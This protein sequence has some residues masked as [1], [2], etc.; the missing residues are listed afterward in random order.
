MDMK[1]LFQ[2]LIILITCTSLFSSCASEDEQKE[3]HY[4]KALEYIKQDNS[5]A[6]IIELRNAVQIDATY[7]DARY[8]LG[9]LYLEEG[10]LKKCFCRAGANSRSRP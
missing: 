7:A 4:R 6:A 8:Q 10:D 5:K 3:R 9:L 2:L 1:R